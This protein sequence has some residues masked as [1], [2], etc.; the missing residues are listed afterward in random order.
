MPVREKMR[1]HKEEK[2]MEHALGEEAWHIM[3][4]WEKVDA[5]TRKKLLLRKLDEKIMVNEQWIADLQYRLE[6]K[7]MIKEWIEKQL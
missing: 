3:Q 7:K 4:I 1:E 2:E 5:P 6:T